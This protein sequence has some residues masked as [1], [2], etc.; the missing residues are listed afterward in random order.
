MSKKIKRG[1]LII[2]SCK[3]MVSILFS[4]YD[5]PQWYETVNSHLQHV[6]YVPKLCL[7]TL[8]GR[9]IQILKVLLNGTDQT[10][11]FVHEAAKLAEIQ[12]CHSV[13]S[14][15]CVVRSGWPIW[16]EVLAGMF[17]ELF[18]ERTCGSNPRAIE[19][20]LC[21][22]KQH[23]NDASPNNL[24]LE[25]TFLLPLN[26]SYFIACHAFPWVFVVYTYIIFPMKE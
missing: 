14:S 6:V 16:K 19:T 20:C 24:D 2:L 26:S 9:K 15:S 21:N 8:W 10:Q 4:Y 3:K 12:K 1:N 22:G 7:Y 11:F 17:S 13:S 23:F 5:G 25:I 18:C